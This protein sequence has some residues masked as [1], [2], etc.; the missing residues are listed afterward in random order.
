MLRALVLALAF[1]AC[2][3]AEPAWQVLARHHASALLS[4]WGTS[5]RDVYVV[6]SDSGDGEGPAVL[7]Y[8][9]AAWQ[10][11]ATGTT[12]DLWWVY[13]FRDGPV[14]LGGAGG[15]ILR[16]RDGAF[17]RM[18]TPS[19]DTVFGIWGASPDDVWAVGGALGGAHG[20]FAWRLR[21]DAWEAANDFPRELVANDALWKV[22]GRTAEDVWMVGTNGNAVRWDGQALARATIGPRASLFTVAADAERFV[23]VGGFGNGAILENDASG[24]HDASPTAAPGLVGVALSAQGDYAVGQLGAVYTRGDDGWTALATG[25]DLEESLHSVWVDPRGGVWAAGGQVLAFPLSDGT[26][27]YRGD[28]ARPAIH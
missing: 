1:C 6:G 10:R 18:A 17:T 21:G 2:S 8:D 24:W 5:E 9:G 25:F 11:L 13:G 15:T 22:T 26:V 7:H 4:V 16:Y 23:A 14:Y 28:Q 20:A 3:S 19:E 12:G 27:L